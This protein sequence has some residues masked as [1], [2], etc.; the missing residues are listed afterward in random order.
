MNVNES[1]LYNSS[2][3]RND[4]FHEV[5]SKSATYIRNLLRRRIRNLYT[6]NRNIINANFKYKNN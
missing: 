1:I 6:L 3:I 5:N 2:K 4:F